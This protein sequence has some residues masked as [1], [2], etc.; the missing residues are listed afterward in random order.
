[1]PPGWWSDRDAA[2][3]DRLDGWTLLFAT[4]ATTLLTVLW[5]PPIS[6]AEP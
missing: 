2:A 6:R 5:P 1:V 3:H 4:V